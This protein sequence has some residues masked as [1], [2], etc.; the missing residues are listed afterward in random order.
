MGAALPGTTAREAMRWNTLRYWKSINKDEVCTK[1]C[2]EDSSTYDVKRRSKE[3]GLRRSASV[4]K[5]SCTFRSTAECD[6]SMSSRKWSI[7]SQ[8]FWMVS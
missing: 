7:S 2:R 4:T 1:K 5:S 3:T 8:A 6:A